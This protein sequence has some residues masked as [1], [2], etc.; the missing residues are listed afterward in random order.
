MDEYVLKL[1]GTGTVV[2]TAAAWY[3]LNKP[4]AFNPNFDFSNQV[5]DCPVSE[6]TFH[7][8][9]N[10]KILTFGIDG[11]LTCDFTSFSTVFQ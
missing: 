5:Q 4:P 11:W 8:T 2:A 10:I 1:L 3:M 6:S 9:N 7:L